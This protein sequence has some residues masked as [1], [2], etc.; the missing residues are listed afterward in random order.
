MI[1][2]DASHLP[3]ISEMKI[4]FKKCIRFIRY[5]KMNITKSTVFIYSCVAND[6]L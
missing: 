6:F 4:E 2:L 1:I 5:E 3:T